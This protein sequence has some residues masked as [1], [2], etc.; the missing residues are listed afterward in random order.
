MAG[1]GTI[2]FQNG[3]NGYGGT[4]DVML[5]EASPTTNYGKHKELRVYKTDKDADWV[6]LIRFD[7]SSI[8]SAS[9]ITA[10]RLELYLFNYIG[11]GNLR[12]GV[13][14]TGWTEMGATWNTRD[15]TNAYPGDEVTASTTGVVS[16]PQPNKSLWV[17]IDV[18]SVVQKWV[19]APSSN[20]GICVW[21]D[22][23]VQDRF[24]SCEYAEEMSLRPKLVVTYTAGGRGH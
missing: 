1:G 21:A 15:G 24:W 18:T 23:D 2:I 3:L 16:V 7:L 8:A 19:R 20:F 17:S 10:A 11:S 22:G 12:F 4:S 13:M 6:C 5:R 9:N 14:N